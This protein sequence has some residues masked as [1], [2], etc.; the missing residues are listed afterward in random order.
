MYRLYHYPLCPFS[1]TTRLVMTE[2]SL[3][4]T[5]TSENFWEKREAFIKMNKSGSVPFLIKKASEEE[6]NDGKNHLLLSGIN[7]IVEYLDEKHEN[8]PIYSGTAEDKAEIR[9]IVDW[10]NVKF[11]NEVVS[12]ILNEKVIIFFKNKDIPDTSIL[13]I[14]VQNLFVHIDYFGYLLSKRGWIASNK[15]SIAD[16]TLAAHISVLDYL[17]M[18]NWAKMSSGNKETFR[19]WYRI[20]KSRPSF[21][22]IL[23][24]SVAGFAASNSYRDLDF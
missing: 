16:L 11:Y 1:R 20:M 4:F 17:G 14:A 24:D 6:I 7:A 9:R 12:Y 8:N 19:E 22:S 15:I 5:L 21:R 13:H 23:Q 18:I 10:V 3:S 2:K